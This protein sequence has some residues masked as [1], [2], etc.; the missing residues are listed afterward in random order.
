MAG[1]CTA[2]H[3]Q[4]DCAQNPLRVRFQTYI[5]APK[6]DFTMKKAAYLFIA[7]IFGNTLFAQ[8]CY[9]LDA[10]QN[11]SI[12]EDIEFL[13]SDR[14]E[15]RAPG[16]EGA[17]IA[18]DYIAKKF[19]R[20]GLT[21][22]GN[23]GFFQEF[24]VA[25][26]VAVLANT[27][28]AI[29]SNTVKLNEQFYP[30]LYSANGTA[31][32]KTVWVNFGITAPEFNFDDY[33]KIPSLTGK[34]AVMDVSSPDGIHPHSA[35]AKYHDLAN[36]VELAKS[37]GAIAVIMVN[38]GDM[39]NDPEAIYRKIRSSG[40]PVVF[41]KDD[42]VAKKLKKSTAVALQ[43]LQEERTADAYNVV[44][45]IDNGQPTTV[46]IG[47]H[48]DH[49]GWGQSGSLYAGEPQIHNGADDNASG[50]AAVIALAETLSKKTELTGHNYLFIAFM[51]E[52]RGL[53]GSNYYVNNPTYPIQNMAYMVN[54][55]MVGR[56]KD[57]NIQ[58]SGI[59]T[60]TQW[61]SIFDGLSC[62]NL[63]YKL[64]SSGVGPSDHTSFYNMGIPVL[65]FFTGSH[66][67][68]HKPTDDADKLNYKGIGTVVALIKT[69]MAKV[70][71]EHRL[72]YK[73]T[74]NDNARNAPKFSVTLGIMPDYM[75]EE[76]GVKVDGVTEGKPAAVAGILK[77]D[78]ITELGDFT[79]GDI[80]AYMNALAS[81]KKGDKTTIKFSRDGKKM[82]SKIQF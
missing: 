65:H 73:E 21:P 36:R 5:C 49:L 64:D 31:S 4:N 66:E 20:F 63:S 60:A 38:L 57:N 78:I 27:S 26:P 77:G 35:Y 75:Y 54:M 16:T 74:A 56:L 71:R 70:D 44:G 42:V 24:K 29:G 41:V 32:G 76:G 40:I 67:D 9:P 80:Y 12:K 46:V 28:L 10:N 3:Q 69:V 19:G 72:E 23:S 58:I 17:D 79:I 22:M 81:F 7:F 82:E 47:A 18:R 2:L 34:I 11:I 52:E 53:L 14:L 25:E 15:G 13:A 33:K 59:G 51:A 30:L 55:D 68:Y 37:K 50:T 62:Y 39:A 1:E 43:V 6:V 48:Y 45:F 8:E 61:L